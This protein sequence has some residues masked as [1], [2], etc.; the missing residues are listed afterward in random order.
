M[1]SAFE[2]ANRSQLHQRLCDAVARAQPFAVLLIELDRGRDVGDGVLRECASR[3]IGAVRR[4][5]LV[6]C[7]R[8]DEFVL[9]I[10]NVGDELEQRVQAVRSACERPFMLDDRP[11]DIGARVGVARYPDDG[12]DIHALIG[13]A[14]IAAQA[15]RDQPRAD[16]PRGGIR[17]LLVDD[18]AILR[19]GLRSVLGKAGDICVV[20]EAS[21]GLEAIQRL[22]EHPVD[23]VVTDLSM[24]RLGGLDLIRRIRAEF[25]AV[26][27][28]ALT[29]HGEEHYA[30][31]C[32]KAGARGFVHKD[33]ASDE[34]ITAVR[35]V[36][37]G[38]SY[39]STALAGKVWVHGRGVG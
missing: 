24:P 31:S 28:L 6:A 5:D 2:L 35:R 14:G 23:M 9:V 38:G 16:A 10:E 29:M 1:S 32:F 37:S 39:V 13:H 3:L 11:F 26:A 22:R 33:S 20:A 7:V 17:L 4:G 30:L 12:T 15:L 21:D 27:V 8:G 34:L 18:H 25:P 19:E 36:A